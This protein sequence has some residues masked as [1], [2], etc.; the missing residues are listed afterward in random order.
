MRKRSWTV[1]Q[2]EE[3][4]KNSTSFRQVLT[5]LGL[6]EAGGNYF[7]LQKYTKE[8]KLDT[9][10]FKGKG[11]NKGLHFGFKPK[12]ALKEILV[13]K[14]YF[15]SYKLKNRLINEG[16]KPVHCE[17]CGWAETSKDGRLPLEIDHINGD[18]HDNRLKNL[19]ILCPNCHSLKPT[20][21]GRNMNR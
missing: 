18:V 2:L 13:R 12:T 8:L 11:W 5:R 6:R 1:Q 9:S 17:E 14:S 4:I 10:H 15:Q 21:R 7:Q 16:L 20:H 19:R 3:A